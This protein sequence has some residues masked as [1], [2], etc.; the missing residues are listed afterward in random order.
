M[1]SKKCWLSGQEFTKYI[2]VRI[3]N[4][5]D[6]DQKQSDLG[7]PCLSGLFWQ[8]SIVLKFFE[9]YHEQIIQPNKSMLLSQG[10]S[11]LLFIHRLKSSVFGKP[12]KISE[13]S[14]IPNFFF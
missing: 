2:K 7:L 10:G 9:I 14:H 8:A 6:P 11:R 3:A 5:K 4:S 12:P 1:L 13:I